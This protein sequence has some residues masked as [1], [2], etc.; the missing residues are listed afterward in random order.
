MLI[1]TNLEAINQAFED[2]TPRPMRDVM[3]EIYPD[4]VEDMNGRFHA[5]HDGYECPIS[6]MQFKGGQYL[7]MEEADL[8]NSYA[9]G[10]RA[11][12]PK[13][14]DL[15]GKEHTWDGTRAQNRAVWMELIRQSRAHTAA[16]SQHVGAVGD[17]L[18]L[19]VRMEYVHSFEGLYGYVF[20]NIMKD[21][22]GNVLIYKGAKAL[23]N[24]NA[25]FKLAA[26]VKEHGE[27]EGTKQTIVWR[28][29]ATPL[30]Q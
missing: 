9:S 30:P 16:T 21:A 5:P 27:R 28:P 18:E 25:K 12:L 20:I 17:K 23:A 2:K 6:G 3:L 29:K 7:P 24:T 11:R 15:E 8:G 22:S 4:A 26:K 10:G 14:T 1:I 13:G 19:E